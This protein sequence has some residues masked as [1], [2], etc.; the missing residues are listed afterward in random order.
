VAGLSALS[1]SSSSPH[2]LRRAGRALNTLSCP[3]YGHIQ[4]PRLK[5]ACVLKASANAAPFSAGKSM[6]ASRRARAA[7]HGPCRFTSG[8]YRAP[9]RRSALPAFARSLGPWF[10]RLTHRT[11]TEKRCEAF[12]YLTASADGQLIVVAVIASGRDDISHAVSDRRNRGKTV[13]S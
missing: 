11:T 8:R 7:S 1:P 9:E 10:S 13:G 2:H 5:G 12:H 3:F 6:S 4:A